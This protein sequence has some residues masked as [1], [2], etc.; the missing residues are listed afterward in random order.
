LTFTWCHKKCIFDVSSESV[1]IYI[2]WFHCDCD[3]EDIWGGV[4][5]FYHSRKHMLIYIFAGVRSPAELGSKKVD[6]KASGGGSQKQS[7]TPLKSY[8][9]VIGHHAR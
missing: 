5:K 8:V 4:A 6:S 1:G 7:I 9:S 2:F 3:S